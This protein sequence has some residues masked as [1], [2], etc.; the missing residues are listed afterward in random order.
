[1]RELGAMRL[2]LLEVKT[3]RYFAGHKPGYYCGLWAVIFFIWILF[4][5]Y[6]GIAHDAQLYTLQALSH[7]APELYQNDIFLRFGSQDRFT[8]F[9]PVY[10]TLIELLGVERAGALLTL[11]GHCLF[12][13]AVFLLANKIMPYGIAVF[14]VGLMLTI[15][16]S[17]GAERVFYYIELFVT[18]RM[19]S[20]AFVLFSVVA[21]LNKKNILAAALLLVA[22]LLHPLMAMAGLVFIL[23]SVYMAY[24][25]RLSLL[26]ITTCAL[27]LLAHHAQLLIRWQFDAEWLGI[28]ENRSTYLFFY[29]WSIDDIA[30]ALVPLISLIIAYVFVSGDTEKRLV[31]AALFTGVMAVLV[32]GF[33]GDF[34]HLTLVTQGQAWR[35]F[36]LVTLV[37]IL[38]LP[39]LILRLWQ[40]KTAGKILAIT[41]I[42][43]WLMRSQLIGLVVAVWAL[44]LAFALKKNWGTA[45]FWA[46]SKWMGLGLLLLPLVLLIVVNHF[47]INVFIALFKG[48][49]LQDFPGIWHECALPIYLLF[50]CILVSVSAYGALH[51][52]AATSFLLGACMMFLCWGKSWLPENGGAKAQYLYKLR[53]LIPVGE[54]VLTFGPPSTIW[55]G[56][57]RPSYLTG[58]QMAGIVFS[59]ATALE[60]D[61]R[62]QAIFLLCPSKDRSFCKNN[63]IKWSPTIDDFTPFC[64]T[65]GVRFVMSATALAAK[66]LVA[67]KVSDQEPSSHLYQCHSETTL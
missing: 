21:W 29:Y 51:I 20:E 52:S 58:I 16:S 42:A 48:S 25:H 62:E 57:Q 18:P 43:A 54:D 13:G 26:I 49:R 46:L 2:V 53:E 3:A 4:F 5:P 66:G 30:N 39:N 35:W 60:A 47:H 36:W 41:L 65:A 11:L 31:F 50:V 17:Y 1:M 40:T 38:F 24:W 6:A 67:V 27:L 7:V 61:R 56:L 15:S 33:G 45:F 12:I 55:I 63:R 22:T 28:I 23:S 10:A 37:A 8:I 34:L 44:V 64:K 59:R 32:H 14:A 9:S 19:L